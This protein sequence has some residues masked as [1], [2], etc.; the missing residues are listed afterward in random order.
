VL[1]LWEQDVRRIKALNEDAVA[2]N[3][4]RDAMVKAARE[5][6]ATAKGLLK[7]IDRKVERKE[8]ALAG[9]S[10]VSE[11]L[12]EDGADPGMVA[13]QFGYESVEKMVADLIKAPSM[14]EAVEKVIDL[15]ML[16]EYG[17]LTSAEA[18]EEAVSASLVNEHNT[19]WLTMEL[20]ALEKK[21]RGG[22]NAE[23]DL[24]QQAQ[25]QEQLLQMK[26]ELKAVRAERD[27]A[28]ESGDSAAL[29]A[30]EAKIAG[31]KQQ[32][33][34]IRNKAEGALSMR[35]MRASAR[36]AAAQV[37]STRAAST[38]RPALSQSAERRSSRD[39]LAKLTDNDLPGAIQA[40][41]EQLYHNQMAARS[42]F[43]SARVQVNSAVVQQLLPQEGQGCR[44]WTVA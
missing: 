42:C 37:L 5:E 32:L 25:A 2:A 14:D 39:A 44:P 34:E 41:R 4:E 23:A 21:T 30:A 22:A 13:Q 3:A 12:T 27:A 29:A 8:E 19:R 26:T 1:E 43:D 38:V 28:K 20:R 33:D 35:I 18:M 11:Y 17:D 31:L 16:R 6:L 10:K 36:M 40:K 9:R 15:R 7:V 24:A